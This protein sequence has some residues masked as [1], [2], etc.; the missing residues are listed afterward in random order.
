MMQMPKLIFFLPCEKAIINQD[1]NA[2]S[3]INVMQGINVPKP[4]TEDAGVALLWCAVS[5]WQKTPD[6]KDRTFE[7]RT[8]LS[9]PNGKEAAES[10]LKFSFSEKGNHR[11]IVKISGFPVGQSGTYTLNLFLRELGS[12]QWTEVANYQIVVTH[13]EG[14]LKNEK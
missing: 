5:L 13:I 10:L 11:N 8:T 1:D 7:Q 9:M 12:E 4:P 6:D 2:L 14:A 3:L